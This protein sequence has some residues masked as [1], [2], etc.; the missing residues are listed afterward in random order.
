[1]PFAHES[2][3]MS[4]KGCSWNV[5]DSPATGWGVNGTPS[6]RLL[7][8]RDKTGIWYTFCP[9]LSRT[10][11]KL[12]RIIRFLINNLMATNQNKGTQGGSSEQHSKDGQQSHNNTGGGN[13]SQQSES[14]RERQ[15]EGGRKGGQK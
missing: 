10:R 14:G 3:C 2:F 1:M 5:K 11:S 9:I 6:G 12:F 13:Q 4:P 8:R 7:L 15:S